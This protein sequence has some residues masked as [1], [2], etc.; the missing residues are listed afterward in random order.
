MKVFIV[1]TKTVSSSPSF[2][3]VRV[4]SVTGNL[5]AEYGRE[6]RQSKDEQEDW[7]WKRESIDINS[8]VASP[9]R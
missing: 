2:S 5:A 6:P 3:N 9:E 4:N 1:F 8:W 7:R